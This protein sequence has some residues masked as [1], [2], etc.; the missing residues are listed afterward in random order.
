MAKNG[1]KNWSKAD[2]AT[3]KREANK[4][5]STKSIADKLGRTT[6]AVRQ[7]ASKDDVSLGSRDKN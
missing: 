4:D 7:Q 1:G 5:K 2:K 3:L 6:E